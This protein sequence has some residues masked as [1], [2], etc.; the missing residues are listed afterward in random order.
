MTDSLRICPLCEAACGLTI[1]HEAGRVI[2]VRG[3]EADVFSHG[4]LC[5]KGASL[6][7][8]N[9]DPDRLDAPLV[10]RDGEFTEVG[11]D[12]AFAEVARGLGMV[13]AAHGRDAVALYVGNPMV[14]TLGI[15]LYFAPLREA[16]GTRNVYTSATLDTM[17]KSVACGLMYGDPMAIP[18]PDVDRTDHLL[19]LGANPLESNGSLWTAPDLPGRIRKLRERGGRLVVVDPARTRT[20]AAADRHVQITPGGDPY[21]LAAIIHVLFAEDLVTPPS[22]DRFDGSDVVRAMAARFPPERVAPVC[23]VDPDGIWELARELGAAR[24]A[25]VY[26]RLGTSTTRF[27]TVTSWLIEVLNVLTGNL[28]RPGGTMFGRA[29]HSVPRPDAPFTTGRWR[30]RVRGLA[31]VS[32]ELP[33]ATLV[34]EIATPGPGQVRALIGVA[35]N[36]VL[37][38]P[39]GE[40]LDG[41]LDDLDFMVSVDPYLNETTRHA[42]VVLPPPRPLQ[43]PQYEVVLARRAVRQVAR[44]SPPAWPL[45]PGRPGEAAMMARLVH[46]AA[47]RGS[48]PPPEAVDEAVIDRALRA[49]AAVPG[50]PLAGR[51]TGELA[52]RLTGADSVERRIDLML[53]LGPA[54]DLLGLRPG[55]NLALLKENPH[56]I[57]LGPLE[58]ALPGVLL[59]PNRK[60]RLAPEELVADV[61]RLERHLDAP[62]PGFQLI[63]RRQLRSLNSWSHNVGSLAGGSTVCRLRLHPAD[64][65]TLGVSDGQPIAVR[66]RHREVVAVAELTDAIA[67]GVVSLPY[68]WGHDRPG[69]RLRTAAEEPGVSIN[70]L[71]DEQEVD[72]L[73]G[74]AVFNGVPVEL[75]PITAT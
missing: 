64:A 62:R 55:L 49:A 52:A 24:T 27:G 45:E 58:P 14:H 72:P 20:A 53:R 19:V 42:D 18:V 39:N 6:G 68:G 47:G 35:G 73:S 11:W 21:L 61:D 34:D 12:E 13:Q 60:V 37:A 70:A 8:F 71:T 29:P 17:P 28:D 66:G 30:S 48:T 44:Y 67:P 57:D 2:A 7:G 56:G 32:G 1:R 69:T 51:E 38:A 40:R 22:P 50:S 23:G 4:Y 65:A 10:R 31:E 74:T 63:S 54:G 59:T 15:S 46:I 16:L 3:D 41:V 43:S 33:T 36:L 5:P 25:A 75:R 26:G 9:D